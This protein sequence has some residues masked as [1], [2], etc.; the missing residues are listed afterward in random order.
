M[1]LLTQ[2]VAE[3][4][5]ANKSYHLGYNAL[6]TAELIY[7]HKSIDSMSSNDLTLNGSMK[8][9]DMNDGFIN[10]KNRLYKLDGDVSYTAHNG[11]PL[12]ILDNGET[13]HDI[14]NNT[15]ILIL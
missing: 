4:L 11:E 5:E 7:K 3:T 12:F 10:S 6:N 9:L 13:C 14:F 1:K 2:E 15:T 8:F